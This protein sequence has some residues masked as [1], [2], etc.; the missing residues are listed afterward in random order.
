MSFPFIFFLIL[1]N[2]ISFAKYQNEEGSGWGT[3]VCLWRIHFDRSVSSA[4]PIYG[5]VTAVTNSV[6]YT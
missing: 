5:T 4:D 6:L 3:H 2:F 1:L